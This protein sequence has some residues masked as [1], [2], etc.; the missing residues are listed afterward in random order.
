MQNMRDA[1]VDTS[2]KY[3]VPASFLPLVQGVV[4][5]LRLHNL[6]SIAPVKRFLLCGAE[7]RGKLLFWLHPVS[8]GLRQMAVRTVLAPLQ[9][10]GHQRSK[11]QV[12]FARPPASRKTP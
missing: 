1:P 5:T 11:P 6:S 7:H 2:P 8:F 3:E 12:S 9:V 10:V 4:Q